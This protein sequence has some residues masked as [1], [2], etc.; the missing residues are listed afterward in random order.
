MAETCNR[1]MTVL[2]NTGDCLTLQCHQCGNV[3]WA[4][5]YGENIA[6]NYAKNYNTAQCDACGE[7]YDYE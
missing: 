4:D 2:Y 3:F 7:I 5:A 6:W 1:N